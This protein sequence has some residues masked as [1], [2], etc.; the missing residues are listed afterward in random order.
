MSCTEL[1]VVEGQ[2]VI[3]KVVIESRFPLIQERG[4]EAECDFSREGAS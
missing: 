1:D 2:K 3:F 4:G